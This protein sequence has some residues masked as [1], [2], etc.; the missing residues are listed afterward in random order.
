MKQTSIEA[1]RFAKQELSKV[2]R[3]VI[4]LAIS[5][6]PP[7]FKGDPTQ[8]VSE[9]VGVLE[10]RYGKLNEDGEYDFT[11]KS[12]VDIRTIGMWST[13]DIRDKVKLYLDEDY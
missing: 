7:E 6:L 8:I 5:N 12:E 9:V 1:N 13:L 2:N 3:E 4:S 11:P 10:R